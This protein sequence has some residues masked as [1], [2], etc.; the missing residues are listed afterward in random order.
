MAPV[1]CIKCIIYVLNFKIARTI[2]SSIPIPQKMMFIMNKKNSY[3][4]NHHHDATIEQDK[5]VQE[6]DVPS[7]NNS[8]HYLPHFGIICCK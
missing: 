6:S 8:P 1:A 2:L 3:C 5:E 4:T 7:E